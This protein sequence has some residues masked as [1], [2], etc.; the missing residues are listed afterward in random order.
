MQDPRFEHL[1]IVAQNARLAADVVAMRPYQTGAERTRA[2]VRR[3]LVMAVATGMVT[4][5]DPATWPG[6]IPLDDPEWEDL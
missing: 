2:I 1:D 3:T 4:I 5:N 6:W